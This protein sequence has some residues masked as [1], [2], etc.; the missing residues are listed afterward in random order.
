M[1][2]L[3]VIF[4]AAALA[5]SGMVLLELK[6][7]N[8]AQEKT[9]KEL[10]DTQ[11]QELDN[12][13]ETLLHE[14]QDSIYKLGSMMER[15][16]QQGAALQ[17]ER[18]NALSNAVLAQ[19]R[20]TQAVQETVDRRLNTVQQSMEERL[21]TV[22]QSVEERLGTVRK[23]MEERLGTVQQS[24]EERLGAVQQTVEERL[25]AIQTDTGKH[26]DEM[27]LTVDEKLQ[28]TLDSR[29]S[30]SFRAVNERLEQ[31]YKGLGE[32][33]SLATGVGDLKK[34]LSGVKTRGILGE[35]QLGAILQ[36]MLTPEQY[37]TNVV[38]RKSSRMPVEFAVK[39]PGTDSESVYLPIDSKFPGDTY[40]ALQDAYETGSKEAVAAASAQLVRAIRL[41]AKDIR[42]K[43]IDPP[44]TT[45]F[46]ILFL[47]FEGLY[48][49]AVRQGL[50]EAL[51][52]EYHITI[53]GPTTLAAL[54]NAL[55]M[56]FRT[57]AIQ[58]S[59]STVWKVLGA[60]KTEFEKFEQVL[61]SAQ[62]R[63][64]QAGAEL[65]KLVGVRSRMMRAK[66]RDVTELSP[67]EAA[68]LLDAGE[69]Q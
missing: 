40:A 44:F 3:A 56:G 32:M 5:V 22:Q 61:N 29:I 39:L 68:G 4:S 69:E 24:M 10:T 9:R 7:L 63:L 14:T 18:L 33:Q 34:V 19:E 57:L 64:N 12:L 50:V 66:L 59:S 8:A 26:L 27:R 11:E 43:Y 55:Q 45:D 62:T 16:E 2:W 25:N 42:D 21:G 53:A 47:P 58:K 41:E 20:R 38:T 46:A 48:A 36:E 13:K 15:A 67:E 37:E 17:A 65:D 60:V 54:L 30:E 23:L 35:V 1:T 6:K 51:Q 28:K 49:E 52:R 31:V